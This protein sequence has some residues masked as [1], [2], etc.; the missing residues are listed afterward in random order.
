[1][2]FRSTEFY[3]F[4]SIFIQ[5]YFCVRLL[6]SFQCNK[7]GPKILF[8]KFLRQVS[9][10]NVKWSTNV[11]SRIYNSLSMRSWCCLADQTSIKKY[12]FLNHKQSLGDADQ[13][14]N[15]LIAFSGPEPRGSLVFFWAFITVKSDLKW[16]CIC[17]P[18]WTLRSH[19]SSHSIH[20]WDRSS[21]P[22]VWLSRRGQLQWMALSWLP[23]LP[24][25]QQGLL[26]HI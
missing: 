3:K 15:A 12:H 20:P 16:L 19:P 6:P 11:L 23:H 25:V 4:C 24:H 10:P 7:L 13:P 26:S 2:Y 22:L 5:H 9:V 14:W 18:G 8:K 21:A 1:M 17:R